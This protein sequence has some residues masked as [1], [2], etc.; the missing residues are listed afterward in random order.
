TNSKNSLSLNKNS[1]EKLASFIKELN[2]NSLYLEFIEKKEINIE[3]SRIY[4]DLELTV[5]KFR[6]LRKDSENP[7]CNEHINVKDNNTIQACKTC[8]SLQAFAKWDNH[9]FLERSGPDCITPNLE[10]RIPE[11]SYKLSWHK[12]AKYLIPQSKEYKELLQIYLNELG[13][14]DEPHK[15]NKGRQRYYKPLLNLHNKYIH[16]DRNILI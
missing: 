13:I 4:E 2:P 15:D 6:I 14:K 10:L 12:S 1:K 11:G 3:I 16:K 9:Y 8:Q 5:S 7:K